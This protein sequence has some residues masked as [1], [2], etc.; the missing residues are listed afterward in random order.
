MSCQSDYSCEVVIHVH[1][2]LQDQTGASVWSCLWKLS[3]PC[4]ENNKIRC[5][6]NF[7]KLT[8]FSP[9]FLQPTPILQENW[10]QSCLLLQAPPCAGGMCIFLCM[11]SALSFHMPVP[12]IIHFEQGGCESLQY[13]S[14]PRGLNGQWP[15]KHCK[16]LVPSHVELMSSIRMTAKTWGH[17]CTWFCL[18]YVWGPFPLQ[19]KVWNMRRGCS[20]ALSL[21]LRVRN[22]WDRTSLCFGKPCFG[23]W[24]CYEGHGSQLEEG[25]SCRFCSASELWIV[26]TQNVREFWLMS[27][28]KWL[29]YRKFDTWMLLCSLEKKHPKYW[30]VL[31]FSTI[32][33][34]AL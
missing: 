2:L 5:L 19:L 20:Q 10:K 26:C 22:M 15:F 9:C 34:R 29:G 32:S 1:R 16:W 21:P 27:H 14:F 23:S 28:A 13:F 31:C 7:W 8:P 33:Y 30:C 11:F 6:A 18:L 3:I 17:P 12:W 4:R 25:Q 24:Q